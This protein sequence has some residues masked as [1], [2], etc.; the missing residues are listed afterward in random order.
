MTGKL[1]VPENISIIPLPPKCP[2]L[3]P[4]GNIWQFMR[5]NWLSNRIFTS[6]DNIIDLCCDAWNR[7]VDQ[8]WRIQSDDVNGH[9]G[10]DQCR[11][12]FDASGYNHNTWGGVLALKP[13]LYAVGEGE[14]RFRDF[15]YRRL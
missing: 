14:V 4:V 15:R 9:V 10:R 13:A 11:L 1:E 2:E 3:N 7:L 8:P 5:D 6:H 12:V